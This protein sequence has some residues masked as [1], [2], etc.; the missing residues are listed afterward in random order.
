MDVPRLAAN[1]T[2]DDCM[3]AEPPVFLLEVPWS[4]ISLPL[5]I[6]S[7]RRRFPN[8]SSTACDSV[9]CCNGKGSSTGSCHGLSCSNMCNL[10]KYFSSNFRASQPGSGQVH[11]RLN[12]ARMCALLCRLCNFLNIPSVSC[13]YFDTCHRRMSQIHSV[14]LFFS[15]SRNMRLDRHASP[16]A[17]LVG[18]ETSAGSTT[19]AR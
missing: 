13:G 12:C 1:F 7:D 4:T 8:S 10:A 17:N 14:I 3:P 6:T 11:L 16:I 2:R 19:S 15:C 5:C 9:S 18:P